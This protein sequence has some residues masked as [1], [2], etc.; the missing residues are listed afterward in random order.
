MSRISD[1]YKHILR[2]GFY[3]G[4]WF[5]L[6]NLEYLLLITSKK[7]K[8]HLCEKENQA[9]KK[10]SWNMFASLYILKTILII[11]IINVWISLILQ[12]SVLIRDYTTKH[13]FQNACISID[14]YKAYGDRF[15]LV[16]MSQC[17]TIKLPFS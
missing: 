17:W 8:K 5:F 10:L 2:K 12:F 11:I 6:N 16:R 14:R 9:I 13:I 7:T 4:T 3:S 15:Q 1:Y